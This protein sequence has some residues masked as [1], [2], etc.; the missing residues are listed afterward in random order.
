MK[1]FKQ[2]FDLEKRIVYFLENSKK[3]F[4]YFILTFFFAVTLRNF[5]ELLLDNTPFSLQG[6]I[7][8]YMSYIT[9]ALSLIL[10]FY[11]L[12]GTPLIKIAKV[13]LPAF[14]ILILAPLLDFLLSWGKGYTIY[15]MFP[16]THPNL[17]LRFFTFFGD[18]SGVG[19]TPG[20]RIEIAIVLLAGFGYFYLKNS[21]FFKSLFYT[22]LTYILIFWYCA[23]PYSVKGI[24]RLVGLE[25]KLRTA[26]LTNF[27][28][29][30]IFF[31]GLIL[32]YSLHR[33]MFKAVIKDIRPFRLLH[34]E[35]M[36][37][38]GLILGIKHAAFS[39]TCNNLAYVVFIPVSIAFA[40]LYSVVTNNIEDYE[41]DKISNKKRPL[42]SSEISLK[43]YKKLRWPF[44][45]VA[46]FYSI[47]VNLGAFLAIL[48][49]IGNYFLYSMPP[50]RLKRIPFFSKIFISLNSLILV[51]LGFVLVT[52]SIDEFP[53]LVIAIFL[54]GFTAAINFIDIKDYEGDKKAGIKTLPVLLG[55]KRS[56][57]I[58]G[59]FFM[60]SYLFI[61]WMMKDMFLLFTFLLLGIA[62]FGLLTRKSYDE[63]YIFLVYLLSL[64]MLIIHLWVFGV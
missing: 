1:T 61:G 24:L 13:I 55:L 9:L 22:L 33:G 39:I 36:F 34:Y 31:I 16:D 8:T 38:L 3:P 28:L 52:G 26:V 45:F 29:F 44:L 41:I 5:L 53:K 27:Y 64:I 7:H 48:L 49:F 51:V 14:I 54:I 56:K 35:L 21:S 15:Y 2:A 63:R 47:M 62:Q 40:W 17:V 23:I 25:C 11:F 57:F 18:F 32:A 50:L 4:T 10:L 43:D 20:M 59:L 58:I 60:T 6:Y 46:L 30:I 19:I 42:V 37:V 12:T